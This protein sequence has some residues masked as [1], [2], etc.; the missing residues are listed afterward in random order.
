M[1][2]SG[3]RYAIEKLARTTRRTLW[4]LKCM[5]QTPPPLPP[6]QTMTLVPVHCHFWTEWTSLKDFIYPDC[7]TAR[8]FYSL[9]KIMEKSAFL[10]EKCSILIRHRPS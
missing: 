7:Q 1:I 10:H 8:F 6:T 2:V 4:T 9:R 5:V 3:K